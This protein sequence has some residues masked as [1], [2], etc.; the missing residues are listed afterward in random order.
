MSLIKFDPIKI[1]LDV[2]FEGEIDDPSTYL[3]KVDDRTIIPN[4]AVLCDEFGVIL[5]RDRA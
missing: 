1:S 4:V 5:C 3:I 2:N